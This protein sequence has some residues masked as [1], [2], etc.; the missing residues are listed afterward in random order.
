MAVLTRHGIHRDQ[1]DI[2]AVFNVSDALASRIAWSIEQDAGYAN[3]LPDTAAPACIP[4]ETEGDDLQHDSLEVSGLA[5]MCQVESDCFLA[6]SA[7]RTGAEGRESVILPSQEIHGWV[8]AHLR[9]VWQLKRDRGRADV[10]GRALD[11]FD[12]GTLLLDPAGNV[13]FA[14]ERATQLLDAGEGLRRAGQSVTATDFDNALR[15]Q[16]TIQ[17]LAHCEEPTAPS[18]SERASVMLVRRSNARPL[19][20][21]LSRLPNT[22]T[23]NGGPHTALYVL[24]PDMDTQSLV[25]ALC[26]AYG[27]TA[28]EAGLAIRLVD[29]LR[30]EAAA[31][32]MHIQTQTARAYLKQIFAKTDTHRQ[33]DLV[34]VILSSIVRIRA[35]AMPPSNGGNGSS[36]LGAEG[37]PVWG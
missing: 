19:V 33:A 30:I 25:T 12:F 20:A 5:F 15:L 31:R 24:D 3:W 1:P 36:R 16:T 28:T 4:F 6:L 35:A 18:E 13:I 8:D 27:L 29:G 34:R 26:R 7:C 23:R 32:D 10:L 9:L 14:N 21:V 2:L 37:L 17:H 22:E 11:L